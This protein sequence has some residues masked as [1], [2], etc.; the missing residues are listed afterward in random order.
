MC[1]GER[2]RA[3]DGCR[4]VSRMPRLILVAAV[5]VVA[6]TLVSLIYL[7]PRKNSTARTPPLHSSPTPGATPVSLSCPPTELKLTGVFEEC[8]AIDK[9]QSCPAGSFDHLR[10]VLLHG[11]K[12]DFLLYIEVNGAYHGPGTYPLTPWPRARLGVPDGVAKVAIREYVTGKLLESTAGSLTIDKSEED[13][14]LFAGLGASAN[15]PVD[16][17][18]SISGWWSCS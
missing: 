11:S 4:D 8:A 13:G 5:A 3:V 9:G 6:I 17:E 12:H 1:D 7:V 14:W 15:S 16:V 2:V 10:I 18:L